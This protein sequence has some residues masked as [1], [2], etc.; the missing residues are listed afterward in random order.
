M[1]SANR[2]S[3]GII[4][5]MLNFSESCRPESVFGEMVGLNQDGYRSFIPS[6][7][8]AT[9]PSSE[10]G[11]SETRMIGHLKTLST[12]GNHL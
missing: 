5:R 11:K 3:A 6:K 9:S 1:E 4:V 8:S 10:L 2:D 12:M 7:V